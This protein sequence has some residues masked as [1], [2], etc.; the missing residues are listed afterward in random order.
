MLMRRRFYVLIGTA[1]VLALG[2]L[3]TRH[4]LSPAV[5]NPTQAVAIA[6]AP[7]VPNTVGFSPEALSNMR[8]HFAKAELRPLVRTVRVTGIVS[9]NTLRFAQISPPSRGRIEAI[10]VAVGE[11]VQAGQRLAVLD[12]FDLSEVRSQVASARAAVT[13][14]TAA[15]ATAEVALTRATDLIGIG[16]IAQSEVDRRRAVL[17]S[18]QAMLRTHQ[19]ELRKWR[20]MEERL[21]PTG[22][23]ATGGGKL[24]L[25]QPGPAD[26][27]GAVVA[28]FAGIVNSVGAAPGDIVDTSRPI[29]SVAD[30][31]TLWVQANVPEHDLAAVREGD[32]VAISVDA[33]PGRQF[34]GR[35]TYIA[36]QV[37]PN[38]GTV[39]VRCEVPNP[40][41]A[42]R[43]NM[44]ATVDIAAPL[45]RN[46]VLVP[47]AALQDVNGQT[48]VFIP[49]GAGRFTWHVVRTGVSSGGF[50]EV[51]E[52]VTAD[53][54][55]V[56][57]GSYWLKAGLLQ[58]S[59][60]DEG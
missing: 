42:L 33:F 9:F 60:P 32:A 46:A 19:A 37:D 53:T 44:F 58:N 1:G 16:G 11:H 40:S 15:A 51:V 39:A 49:A 26:S 48:A 50:T 27:L 52:G 59:I 18:A 38:T 7:P 8:L 14:A 45:D 41:G 57:D 6:A 24:A 34:T 55:V 56:T 12:A 3:G 35:V 31:S 2:A 22:Q 17:A 4:A 5:A 36:D 23:L 54:P 47:D 20:G 29:F 25:A 21:M 28:P 10:D 30:L 43:I 13:D